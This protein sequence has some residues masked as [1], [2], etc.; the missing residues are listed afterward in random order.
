MSHRWNQCCL[1]SIS[2]LD[3]YF[4]PYSLSSYLYDSPSPLFQWINLIP[5]SR[6]NLKQNKRKLPKLPPLPL[7]VYSHLGTYDPPSLMLLAELF[8]LLFWAGFSCVLD[9]ISFHL[10]RTS[11]QFFPLPQATINSFSSVYTGSIIFPPQGLASAVPFTYNAVPV[12]IHK[13][14]LF[15]SFGSLH[16][17]HLLSILF[18]IAKTFPSISHFNFSSWYLLPPDML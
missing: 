18:K 1:T 14:C 9:F 6:R 4:R 15:I 12:N 2:F 5:I 8:M 7:A 3:S 17:Y 10:S 13:T 16:K 11:S